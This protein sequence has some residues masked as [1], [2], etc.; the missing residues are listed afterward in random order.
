MFS[1]TFSELS[2]VLHEAALIVNSRLLGVLG[3]AEDTEAGQPITALHL[4]MGRATVDAPRVCSDGP[5][6]IVV[7]CSFSMTSGTNSGINL[8]LWFTRVWI[9]HTNGEAT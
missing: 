5:V 3:H 8:G 4:M 2:T 6:S 7:E 9:G 1:G